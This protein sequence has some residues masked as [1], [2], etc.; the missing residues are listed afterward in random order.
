MFFLGNWP[1]VSEG[2][3]LGTSHLGFQV[4]ALHS[5]CAGAAARSITGRRDA[6]DGG[7]GRG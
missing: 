1:G 6:E 2:I 7:R 3:F 5:V 4:T